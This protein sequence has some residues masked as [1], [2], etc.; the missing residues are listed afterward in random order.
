MTQMYQLI[1]LRTETVLELKRMMKQTGKP[2]MD[3]MI[4]SMIR[5]TDRHRESLKD[6]GWVS[7]HAG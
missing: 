2:G 4:L 6:T 1:K 7:F 3:H 5:T